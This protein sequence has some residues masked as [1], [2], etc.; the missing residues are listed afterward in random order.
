MLPVSDAEVSVVGE[1]AL[2]GSLP[3]D[4]GPRSPAD[5]TPEGDTLS[6]VTRNITQRHEELWGNW[7]E[8]SQRLNP[9][10]F[11]TQHKLITAVKRCL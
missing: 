3:G 4:S 11:K 6:V 9:E 2:V 8:K 10:I 1:V 7:G 5:L